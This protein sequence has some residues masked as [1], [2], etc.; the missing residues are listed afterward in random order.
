[1]IVKD[2]DKYGFIDLTPIHKY[3]PEFIK[4]VTLPFNVRLYRKRQIFVLKSQGKV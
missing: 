1:M 3:S 4:E 2:R